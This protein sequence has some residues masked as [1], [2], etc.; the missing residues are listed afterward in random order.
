MSEDGF[1]QVSEIYN[2]RLRSELVILSACQTARGRLENGEGILGLPRI[3]FYSG[4]RSVLSTLW[5]IEDKSTARF[6]KYFYKYLTKGFDKSESLRLA[7]IKMIKSGYSHP[8]YWA[9]FVLNGEYS[10]AIF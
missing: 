7:K 10:S 1:L 4:A 9:G 3:F 6:M 2:L 5:R 8:F